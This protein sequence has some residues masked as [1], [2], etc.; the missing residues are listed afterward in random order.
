MHLKYRWIAEYYDGSTIEEPEDGKSQIVA[1]DPVTDYQPSA[2]R[3]IDRDKLV[4]FHIYGVD[5]EV[6]SE[7]WSVDLRD[8]HFEHNGIPFIVHPQFLD[9]NHLFVPSKLDLVFFREVRREHDVTSTVQ[10]DGTANDEITN[11]REYVNRYFFGWK[12]NIN[13]KACTYTVG[14]A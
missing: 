6:E 9:E 8:G 3:D 11:I 10:E 12:T 4:K 14:I 1:Y 7:R 5:P 13:G 2:F